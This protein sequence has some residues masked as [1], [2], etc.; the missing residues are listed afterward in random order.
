[1]PGSTPTLRD[2]VLAALNAGQTLDDLED[3]AVDPQTGERSG[4]RSFFSRLKNG[5]VDRM[6]K[7]GHLRGIAAALGRPYEEVRQAA[8][9][10]WL[11]AE[12]A[13][14]A[15]NGALLREAERLADEVAKL[16]QI[17]EGRARQGS[18]SKETA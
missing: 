9:A 12:D 7:P 5:G 2:M 14:A 10:Q 17:A 6:P 11:P 4:S 18:G 8:I 3:R 1:M 15:D 13:A 16:R